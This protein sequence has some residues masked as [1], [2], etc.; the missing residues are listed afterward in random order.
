MAMVYSF[1]SQYL[2]KYEYKEAGYAYEG[3]WVKGSRQGEGKL[4]GEN[5][6]YIGNFINDKPECDIYIYIY[7]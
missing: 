7:I 3:Q 2:G 1:H 6:V 5:Y 4:H